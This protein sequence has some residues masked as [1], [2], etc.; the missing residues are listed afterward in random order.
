MGKKEGARTILPE[1]FDQ[2]VTINEPRSLLNVRM[3]LES[4]KLN[5]IQIYALIDATDDRKMLEFN[6]ILLKTVDRI[7]ETNTYVTKE[8]K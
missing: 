5:I 3:E 1:E 6:E 8:E 7:K 2:R 4:T